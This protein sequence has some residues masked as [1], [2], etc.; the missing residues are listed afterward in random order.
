[1]S[2]LY[3]LIIILLL[4]VTLL[5]LQI[6]N[7][8]DTKYSITELPKPINDI[9]LKLK[10]LPF[11][12]LLPD[13]RCREMADNFTANLNSRGGRYRYK[14]EK[15][16]YKMMHLSC[17]AYYEGH[18]RSPDS[19]TTVHTIYNLSRN[20]E[21]TSYTSEMGIFSNKVKEADFLK[22]YTKIF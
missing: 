8:L 12:P 11:N 21:V 18:S 15:Y 13:N 5:F 14:V 7:T 20:K 9:V 3:K 2:L 17:Y 10:N 6:K 19:F 1:M 16:K 4:S 22:H